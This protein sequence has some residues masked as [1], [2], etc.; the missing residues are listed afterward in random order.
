MMSR[1]VL[2]WS[3]SARI[4]WVADWNPPGATWS[5]A[6]GTVPGVGWAGKY[7]ER[8]CGSG[9]PW[10]RKLIRK[11][12]WAWRTTFPVTRAITSW[13]SPFAK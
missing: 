2:E 1:R 8:S 10:P 12:A 3:M 7:F 13:N 5:S 6:I 9:P 4:A 11:S